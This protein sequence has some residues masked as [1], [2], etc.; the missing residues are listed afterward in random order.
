MEDSEGCPVC[1]EEWRGWPHVHKGKDGEWEVW[2]I[3]AEW[4]GSTH[5]DG[6]KEGEDGKPNPKL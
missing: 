6:W 4:G 2:G 3:A 5:P 1:G